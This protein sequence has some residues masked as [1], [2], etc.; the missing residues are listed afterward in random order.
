LAVLL[1]YG[2]L[3]GVVW[4]NRFAVSPSSLAFFF[5]SE[6]MMMILARIMFNVVSWEFN[7][8]PLADVVVSLF[9]FLHNY[10]MLVNFFFFCYW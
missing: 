1:D 3:K 8:L 9:L 5:L 2:N 7:I 6:L 4:V 10:E